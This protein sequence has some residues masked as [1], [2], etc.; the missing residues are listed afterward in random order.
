MGFPTDKLPSSSK[1]EEVANIMRFDIISGA[2]ETGD[3]VSENM[4]SKKYNVSRSPIREA[5]RLLQS[6]GLVSLERMGA[7]INGLSK[8]D[9]EEINDMRLLIESFCMKK[10]ADKPS[11]SLTVF[12]NYSIEQMKISVAE[13]NFIELAVQDIAFHEAIIKESNH[14]RMLHTWN[15]MKN[16]IMTALLLATEE[17]S[18]L[19]KEQFDFLIKKHENIVSA[20]QSGSN[21]DIDETLETHFEDTRKTVINVLF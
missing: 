6:E 21:Q 8:Q 15:G 7:S 14:L 10:C 12:L 13:N 3:V 16:I 19:E 17:R 5:L 11:A 9:M 2:I 4:L 1:G 18:K 20:I